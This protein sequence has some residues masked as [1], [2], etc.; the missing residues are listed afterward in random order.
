MKPVI[1]NNTVLRDGHTV[2]V[3]RDDGGPATEAWL[4]KNPDNPER[5]WVAFRI[6][7][8]EH[9]P[10]RQGARNQTRPLA[11]KQPDSRPGRW[12]EPHGTR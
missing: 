9:R 8:Q 10:Q 2:L 4:E 1:L 3:R 6:D 5:P 11:F 12:I 7:G